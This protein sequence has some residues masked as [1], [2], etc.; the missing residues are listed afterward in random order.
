[1]A[2]SVGPE[3]EQLRT[4]HQVITLEDGSKWSVAVAESR[5]GLIAERAEMRR[6]LIGAF[7][8][9]AAFGVLTVLAADLGHRQAA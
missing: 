9:V 5:S 6:S 4:A 1:M 2:D 3:D 8:L 7:A